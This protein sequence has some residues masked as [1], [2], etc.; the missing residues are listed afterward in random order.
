ME[1]CV[2]IVKIPILSSIKPP[3][4]VLIAQITHTLSQLSIVVPFLLKKLIMSHKTIHKH[5]MRRILMSLTKSLKDSLLNLRAIYHVQKKLLFTMENNVFNVRILITFLIKHQCL[6]PIA[7]KTHT[8]YLLFTVV[9][10]LSKK[11]KL[12]HQHQ[13]HKQMR[14]PKIIKLNLKKKIKLQKIKQ[15]KRKTKLKKIRQKYQIR[16]T[17]KLHKIS[18]KLQ[19]PQTPMS[20][21]KLLKG[22]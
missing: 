13:N 5:Q 1:S 4:L 22:N 18:H 12:P 9:H 8:L 14:H 17:M 7:Q 11:I 3:Y 2:S 6:V 15:K 10:F 19:T 20:L 16:K 21:T